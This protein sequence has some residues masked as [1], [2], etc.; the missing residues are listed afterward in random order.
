MLIDLTEIEK[1]IN[2]VDYD[3]DDEYE[4]ID[5]TCNIE[6]CNN[7]INNNNTQTDMIREIADLGNLPS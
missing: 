5:T 6:H 3:Y 1:E 7:N 4:I 2:Y